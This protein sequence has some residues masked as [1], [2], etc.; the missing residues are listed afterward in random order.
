M[1]CERVRVTRTN[2]GIVCLALAALLHGVGRFGA[3]SLPTQHSAA[4]DD[5]AVLD[6]TANAAQ[7]PLEG[8][9]H[10]PLPEQYIWSSATAS[11]TVKP[12]FSHKL[13]NVMEQTE[14][15]C[16]RHTFEVAQVPKAATLYVA[17]PRWEKVWINGQLAD[18]VS[19]DLSSPIGV[20]V[21]A[22]DATRFLKSGR[23]VVA[24]EAVRG[25]G[26]KTFGDDPLVLQQH[27]G[28]TLVAKVLP[29]QQGVDATPLMVSDASWKTSVA[30]PPG[31]QSP[32]FDD[33]GW[34]KVHDFGGIE[35]SSALFEGNY[36]A[37]LYAWPGYDGISPFLAHR[38]VS[39]QTVLASYEGRSRFQDLAAL[40]AGP[41]GLTVDFKRE[42]ADPPP[43]LLLDFGRELAGRLEIESDSDQPVTL[44]L[45]Y[46]ESLSETVKSPYLGVNELVVGPHAVAH[47]PKTGFRFVRLQLLAGPARMRFKS[48]HVDQIF[49]PVQYQGSFVSSDPGLNRIWSIGA[50]TAH[51]CMQDSLWDAPKRDRVAWS[52]DDDVSVRVIDDVFLDHDL[53]EATMDRLLGRSPATQHV[54]GI[55]G[56][57][58]FWFTQVAEYYRHTGS[59]QL[60]ERTHQRAVELLGHIDAEFDARNVYV[61]KTGSWVFVDWSPELN[62]DTPESRRVTEFEFYRAYRDGAW[63]LRQV[64]DTANA[65]KYEQ[66]AAAIKMA[67]DQYLL[68]P[69][70]GTYGPRWQT[71]AMAVVSGIAGPER[72]DAIWNSV[73]SKVGRQSDGGLI[74]SPYYNYYV[75]SAMARMGHRKEALDWIRTYWGGMIAEGATS[76]W[77]GYDPAWYKDNFHASLQSDNQSGYFV[78]LA[79]AF[80][81][82]PTAWL[83]EEVLGIRSTGPG[84]ST[85]DIRPELAGLAYARGAEP[86]P[87]GLLKV[88]VTPLRTVVDLP[89]GVT[90]RVSVPTSG[91]SSQV[92]VN[93]L[94][95]AAQHDEENTR[96]VVTISRAGHYNLEVR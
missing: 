25:R 2:A 77:E 56:Y 4:P 48:I 50:Y 35:D 39:A 59:R 13:P 73:L 87:H 17:G 92:L 53:L 74:I 54:N 63:L 60:L 7:S 3:Q 75:V 34:Q 42:S 79:H 26:L 93:G 9:I 29:A 71:N 49:Y 31:W 72:Y 24:I 32:S 19:A 61:N 66:R 28:Q 65:A 45:Q 76:F 43:S 94:A 16:F 15:H 88:D 86:T 96:A 78:S 40:T 57:S 22:T 8:H 68:D 70:T 30:A 18:E 64:G 90:A 85:V 81:S 95:I 91:L 84:F 67:C 82:G 6:P 69:A 5:P 20:Q 52:G 41:G 36:D 23:N 89:D 46:G 21:F 83:M 80:A 14:H 12:G 51:L 62:G 44:S 47:G 33:A 38:A 37:G 10:R 55:P 58:S 27:L 1:E 11:E